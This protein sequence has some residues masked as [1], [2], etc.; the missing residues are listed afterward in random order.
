MA[1]TTFSKRF[2]EPK[3]AVLPPAP[4]PGEGRSHYCHSPSR[5]RD[6]G[7][8]RTVNITCLEHLR[9][10]VLTLPLSQC[11]GSR[12]QALSPSSLGPAK[13]PAVPTTCPRLAWGRR[14]RSGRQGRRG[15]SLSPPA[16]P[17]GTDLQFARRD[18]PHSLRAGR[19]PSPGPRRAV[20]TELG[21]ARP[22]RRRP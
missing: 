22:A 10:L 14:G 4:T 19:S 11:S 3:P 1:A 18:L 15:P 7:Q 17:A 6:S 21:S 12:V 20:G 16:A 8:R 9:C 2:R 5:N 13:S